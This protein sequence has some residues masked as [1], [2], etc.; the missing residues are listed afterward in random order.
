[1]SRIILLSPK[2]SR[3]TNALVRKLCCN[4]DGGHCILLDDGDPCVCPQLITYSHIIF[5]TSAARCPIPK[6]RRCFATAVWTRLE[7]KRRS[8]SWISSRL[9][10][11]RMA[12]PRSVYHDKGHDDGHGTLQ[13]L[14]HIRRQRGV[15]RVDV[16]GDGADNIAGLITVEKTNG[17]CCQLFE[18][19]VA[20]L[21]GNGPGKA[22][23]DHVKKISQAR[24]NGIEDN[25]QHG[26]PQNRLH[27]YLA[28]SQNYTYFDSSTAQPP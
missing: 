18:H 20:H 27:I 25:H 6:S 24:R 3:R 15:Y 23:H 21:L 19:I 4:Y 26:T 10:N 2:Q 11:C 9:M 12:P 14:Q 1:M 22:D 28:Y 16:V 8:R 13:D 17:Q 7:S 5:S